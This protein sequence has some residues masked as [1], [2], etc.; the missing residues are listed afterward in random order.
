MLNVP[1]HRNLFFSAAVAKASP[2][3]ML[4]LIFSLSLGTMLRPMMTKIN[5]FCVIIPE[6]CHCFPLLMYDFV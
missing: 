4:I 3:P 2:P 1:T 6:Q 5:C